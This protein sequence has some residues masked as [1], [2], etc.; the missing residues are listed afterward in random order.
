MVLLVGKE[1]VVW[2]WTFLEKVVQVSGKLE[3]KELNEV[4][5]RRFVAERRKN[6]RGRFVALLEFFGEGKKQMVCFPEGKLGIGWKEV[7][8]VLKDFFGREG[9]GEGSSFEK[10]E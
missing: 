3:C 7:S 9:F 6:S 5:G 1:T 2:F 4:N 10:E 8:T